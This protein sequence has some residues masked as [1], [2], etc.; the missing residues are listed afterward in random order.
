VFV[1]PIQT[2]DPPHRRAWEN[3]TIYADG[4][5]YAYFNTTMMDASPRA[6]GLDIAR[7]PDGVHWDFIARDV[8]RIEGAHA[9][10]GLLRRGET[11]WYYPTCSSGPGT[12]HFKV[13]ASTD[14]TTWKHLGDEYDVRPDPDYYAERWDEM[15]VLRDQEDGRD[16]FFGYIT[17]EVRPEVGP[18]SAGML[19]SYDGAHWEVL[20]PP[21][22][23]WGELPAQHME[24]NFCERI[25]G[26]YYL[27]LSGRLYLDS[28]GYS[29][30]TFVSESAY[31]PFVPDIAAFRLSGTSTR[32]TTWLGH[33]IEAPDGTLVALWL[34]AR[35]DLEIPSRGFAIG[36]LK[37]LLC[38][39]GHLRLGYWSGNERAKG[40]RL[41]IDPA[42]LDRVHP[43]ARV[44][45]ERDSL[46]AAEHS[47]T[48]AAGRDG[49]LVMLD[50]RLD[51]EV[52]FIME[53]F[54]TVSERRGRIATHHQ[55]A[56]AGFYFD[57]TD[58][59]DTGPDRTMSGYAVRL[60]TLGVT[61]A[62][63][64]R[65][66]PHRITDH[67]TYAEAGNWLVNNRSGPLLGLCDFRQDDQVGPFGHASFSGVRHAREHRFRVL[68][69][70]G[71]VELYVDDSYVQTY[72][73]PRRFTGAVGLLCFDGI[74]VWRDLG[75]W[76]I[77]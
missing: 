44:R 25:D 77:G 67:D 64:I 55:A 59:A 43:A 24:V 45:S 47:I 8:C 52:G 36:P 27:S 58:G 48:L 65:L 50:R 5:Y 38:E 13:F 21:A 40:D 3:Y 32:D 42:R 74:S 1:S 7:S 29:L 20:P 17:A 30:Y 39:N 76:A 35:Q 19:R 2:D 9:G 26:R 16:V 33:T 22:I 66:A 72:F 37:R 34:S 56:A 4:C 68:A 14:M 23:D 11:I 10:F 46:E 57:E 31:G 28:L 15:C 69:R 6:Y 70:R 12:I 53:G 75:A 71:F 18:P 62:G 54:L 73:L 61:R 41:P 60:E 49:A 63:S 51:E